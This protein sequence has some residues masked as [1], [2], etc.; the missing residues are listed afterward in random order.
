[1]YTVLLCRTM[2]LLA[3]LQNPSK[4]LQNPI[5]SI[6]CLLACLQNTHG[7]PVLSPLLAHLLAEYSH[8][9]DILQG[10]AKS[11]HMQSKFHIR[12]LMLPLQQW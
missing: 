7:Y 2:C 5:T 12:K 6:L 3:C 11:H 4:V 8:L 1:M 9:E 10:F